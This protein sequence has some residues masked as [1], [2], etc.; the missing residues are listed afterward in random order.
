MAM[1]ERFPFEIISVDSSMVYKGMD[2]GTA[3]PHADVLRAFPHHLIDIREPDDVYSAAEFC[4]DVWQLIRDIGR[5]GRYPLLVGGSMF[6]FRALEHGLPVGP[7]A[8][9]ELRRELEKRA[10]SEG[11]PALYSELQRLDPRRA[12]QIRPTDTQRVQRAL[13]IVTLTG[14]SAT[15]AAAGGRTRRRPPVCKLALAPTDRGWLHA[16]IESRFERML[17][18]GLIE[19]VS[20]LVEE[21]KLAPEL[22]ALRMVGYRQVV[23]YLSDKLEYNDMVK[24]GNAATRQLA[25]RQLTWLRNQS[26]VTWIDCASRDLRGTMAAYISGKL[27]TAGL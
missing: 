11:W 6:Y 5:R 17:Q 13:E 14:R 1:S 20:R 23:Q 7:A 26:G 3:K 2:I 25:K 15:D 21:R 8:H 19:E 16:R 10:Q 27:A 9:P 4:R 12:A 24:R 22:P 18:N